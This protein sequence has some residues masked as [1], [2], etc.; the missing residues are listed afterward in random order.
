MP[1][2]KDS[3]VDTLDPLPTPRQQHANTPAQDIPLPSTPLQPALDLILQNLLLAV[4]L[5]I[6]GHK[7]RRD[8]EPVRDDVHGAFLEDR[9]V[10]EGA[11]EEG[12]EGVVWCVRVDLLSRSRLEGRKGGSRRDVPFCHTDA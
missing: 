1:A 4:R 2:L 8:R 7:G 12:A 10:L 3:L 9:R 5:R 6:P 11:G